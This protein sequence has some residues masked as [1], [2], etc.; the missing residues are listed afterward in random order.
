M[1]QDSNFGLK[2]R[3]LFQ[4]ASILGAGL[5]W[6]LGK[7][8]RITMIGQ[9]NVEEVWRQGKKA[10]YAFWHGRLLALSYTHRGQ[11]IRVLVSLHR[12]G[13]FIARIIEKLGFSPVRGSTTRGGFKALLEMVTASR[14]ADIGISPDGPRGPR[15]KVQPGATYISSRAL[16]PIVPLTDSASS[17]WVINSWDRFLIPKPFSKVVVIV[18]EAIWVDSDADQQKLEQK[19]QE[20]EAKLFAL[21]EKADSYFGQN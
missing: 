12:D 11:G 1:N 13:E 21:T 14:K 10:C 20:L 2:D 19:N 18:G 8:W 7:T 17:A 9:E 16:I 4:V 6:L 3:I 5:V 15:W